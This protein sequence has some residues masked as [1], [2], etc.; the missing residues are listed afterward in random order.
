[1]TKIQK[2]LSALAF[3]AIIAAWASVSAAVI[4]EKDAR[5]A[6]VKVLLKA[7]KEKKATQSDRDELLENITILVMGPDATK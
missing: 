5:Q 3:C 7:L 4:A 1:M 2:T 6:R